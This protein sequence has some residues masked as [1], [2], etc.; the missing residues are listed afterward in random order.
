MPARSFPTKRSIS[1]VIRRHTPGS[2]LYLDEHSFIGRV[3]QVRG[4]RDVGVDPDRLHVQVTGF[5]RRWEEHDG[6]LLNID[7]DVEV[8]ELVPIAPQSVQWE[9]YP[10][11]YRCVDETC[12]VYHDAKDKGFTGHCR[13]CQGPLWQLPYVYYHRCGSLNYL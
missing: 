2:L 8:Q 13:R 12:Q 10:H 9:P 7:V 11:A 4:E 5:L 6:R 1:Q 3:S